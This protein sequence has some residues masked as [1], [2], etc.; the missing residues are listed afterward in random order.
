[1]EAYQKVYN[2][3]E[4]IGIPYEIVEHPA[5]FTTEEADKY[6]EGK[7][8]V[9]TK[10]LFL[11][12]RKKSRYYLVI[13]DDRKSLDMKKLGDILDEKGMKFGS[14]EKLMEKLSL[15]PGVVSIFGFL[16]NDSHDINI[17]V[18]REMLKDKIVTFH[19][20]D[21]TKTIFISTDDMFKFLDSL[22][23]K[24]EIIDL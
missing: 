4:D 13:M 17:C 1:M 21:N 11:C 18:D 2:Y 20:N 6:I 24:Y 7:E 9:P 22:N 23:Y 16:N 19:P 12:N 15:S 14:S 5:V 10:T 3:L 8:G